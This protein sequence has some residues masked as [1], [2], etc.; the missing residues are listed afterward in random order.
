M[1]TTQ[2]QEIVKKLIEWMEGTREFVTTQ[3]PDYIQQYLRM[4]M[5][6][7]WAE[8]VFEIFAICAL[9]GFMFFCINMCG[10]YE[11][12]CEAPTVYG[13]GSFI[14]IIGVIYVIGG[15]Y[16]TTQKLIAIHMAPKVF[17]LQHLKELIK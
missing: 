14:P 3:A 13:M 11:K 1:E 4:A 9:L 2:T 6:Q 12:S 15:I 7:A 8:L 17:I 16:F 10:K 5:V